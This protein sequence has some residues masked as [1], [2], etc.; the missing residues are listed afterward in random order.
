MSHVPLKISVPRR[1]YDLSPSSSF[2]RA[3]PP[4]FY[5]SV[6]YD[7]L[8]SPNWGAWVFGLLLPEF[9]PPFGPQA[10]SI[11]S[12][13]L[14][15]LPASYSALL[16]PRLSSLSFRSPG[17]L[18]TV[19]ISSFCHPPHWAVGRKTQVPANHATSINF[20]WVFTSLSHPW[21]SSSC[22][23]S[24]SVCCVL[25]LPTCAGLIVVPRAHPQLPYLV[26]WWVCPFSREYPAP[27]FFFEIGVCLFIYLFIYFWLCWVF[28]SVRGLSLVA[29]SGGPLFIAVHGPLTVAASL[30]AEHR[31]QTRRLSSCGSRT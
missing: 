29:A 6:S 17:G 30:V 19:S 18:R 12:L 11:Q 15:D 5:N 25:Y 7:S 31:L 8:Q 21:L 26:L 9:T 3:S 20:W 14:S 27:F 24:S 16:L 10:P 22:P 28:V 2:P 23:V 13:N 4:A 1:W